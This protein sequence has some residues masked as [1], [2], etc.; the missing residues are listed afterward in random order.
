MDNAS[1]LLLVPEIFNNKK[2]LQEEKGQCGPDTARNTSGIRSVSPPCTGV[3]ASAS[4]VDV[5]ARANTIPH[6]SETLALF[7]KCFQ[8]RPAH[9]D[10][11]PSLYLWKRSSHTPSLSIFIRMTVSALSAK[12]W[13]RVPTCGPHCKQCATIVVTR[14]SMFNTVRLRFIVYCFDVHISLEGFKVFVHSLTII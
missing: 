4:P 10:R 12:P 14:H 13:V 8:A 11:R 6:C 9:V 1:F 3:G 5:A 2:H 7:S